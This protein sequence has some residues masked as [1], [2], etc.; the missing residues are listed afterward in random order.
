MLRWETD[1]EDAVFG[2]RGNFFEEREIDYLTKKLDY[3][4]IQCTGP[5]GTLI[6]TDT[7]GIHK[8]TTPISGGRL[9][10]GHYY[11]LPRKQAAS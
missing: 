6:L 11:E 2:Q 4:P 8:A 9:M 3:E 7:C 5:A 10:L 1:G